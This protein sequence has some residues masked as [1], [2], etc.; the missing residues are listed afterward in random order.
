MIQ[1][2]PKNADGHYRL[3]LTYL[4]FDAVRNIQAAYEE[5]IKT[6][7]LDVQSC[8]YFMRFAFTRTGR[9]LCFECDRR[10]MEDGH[11]KS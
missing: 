8:G 4:K 7:E 6:V 1:I 2:D 9:T 11:G 5:L 10:I 3:A